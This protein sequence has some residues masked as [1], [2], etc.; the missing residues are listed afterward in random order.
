MP[1]AVEPSA[2]ITPFYTGMLT[3]LATHVFFQ[4]LVSNGSTM[5]TFAVCLTK[6]ESILL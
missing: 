4:V 1:I 3:A 6:F 2:E 5:R